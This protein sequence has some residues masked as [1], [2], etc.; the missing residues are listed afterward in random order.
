VILYADS[1]T[2]SMD[3]AIK[4]TDR[5]RAVQVAYNTKHGITPQTI[6][7]QIHDITDQLRT[8]HDKAVSELV[9]IDEALA[10]SNPKLLMKQKEKQMEEAVKALDFETAALIRDELFVLE[11]KF[12]DEGK[13]EAPT[14]R[15]NRKK[16]RGK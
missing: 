12:G 15:V 4:E 13:A 2:R 1:V 8:E 9:K 11:K 6:K 16:G 7:K 10:R 14:A 5:R 3:A